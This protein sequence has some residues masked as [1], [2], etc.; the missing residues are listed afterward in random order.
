M[1]EL[2]HGLELGARYVLMR[3]LGRGGSAEVWLADDRE[4]GEHVALKILDD[5]KGSHPLSKGSHPLPSGCD[6]SSFVPVHDQLEID[7]RRLV[8]MEYMPGG[9]LGQFRGR[10]FESWG[11]HADE[12]AAALEALHAQGLVHRDL[13]CSNVLLDA[14][15]RA[16]LS[17]FGLAAETGASVPAGGSPY[18]ASP[19]QLRGEAAQPADDLY[20]FGALLYELIAGHPPYYPEITR[21]LV[22]HEPVPPLVPRGVVPVGVRE[23]A[24]RLLAKS[25]RERP[26]SAADVRARLAA[27]ATGEGGIM[28]PLAHALPDPAQRRCSRHE[29][30]SPRTEG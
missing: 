12:V 19:Q 5:Q 26:A 3:R 30:Y 8:V 25:P 17:D 24:L 13:K 15:G 23:L 14:E 4:G 11:R 22:L 16:R 7:G 21:D 6:P 10:S 2:T 29:P 1:V 28:E 9:D 20:A 18:N 27:A